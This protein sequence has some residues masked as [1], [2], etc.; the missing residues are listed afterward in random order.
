[1]IMRRAMMVMIE[2]LRHYERRVSKH[3]DHNSVCTMQRQNLKQHNKRIATKRKRKES[4]RND[5]KARVMTCFA[6][7]TVW[8]DL[9]D[10]L[11]C[12]TINLIIS[13]H[14]VSVRGRIQ[15]NSIR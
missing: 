7:I 15:S 13:T 12:V 9:S 1:M 3:I 10:N 8:H 11:V 2:R 14:L 4:G 6:S 5:R